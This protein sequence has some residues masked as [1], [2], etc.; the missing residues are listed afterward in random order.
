MDF[1]VGTYKARGVVVPH[2]LGVS[3]RLQQR[4]R[5]QYDVLHARDILSATT[6]CSDVLHDQLGSLGNI[7]SEHATR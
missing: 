7:I 6:Y 1:W 2:R 5:V 4:I 3:K